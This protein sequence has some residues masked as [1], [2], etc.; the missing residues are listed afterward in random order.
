MYGGQLRRRRYGPKRLRL[1]R[2]TCKRDVD[3]PWRA[4]TVTF[5]GQ[6]SQAGRYES[7]ATAKASCSASRHGRSGG[8]PAESQRPLPSTEYAGRGAGR[9][10]ASVV[11]GN[12]RAGSA[13]SSSKMAWVNPNQVVSPAFVQ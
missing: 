2:L 1:R 9:G 10:N 13:P 7:A 11:V 6:A 12:T 3:C 8:S 4:I 5:V